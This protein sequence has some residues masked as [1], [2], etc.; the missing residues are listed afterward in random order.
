LLH[1][2]LEKKMKKNIAL[3]TL[4][5]GMAFLTHAEQSTTAPSMP[6]AQ[7]NPGIIGDSSPGI[8]NGDDK[9]TQQQPSS[10]DENNQGSGDDAD[11]MNDPDPE[12][13]IDNNDA[14][15]PSAQGS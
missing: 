4:L 2:L 5:M 1:Q 13:D 10:A 8:S 7:Q 6:G 11:T 3:I 15:T 9:N 14:T 12:A